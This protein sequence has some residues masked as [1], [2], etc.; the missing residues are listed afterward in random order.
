M[1]CFSVPSRGWV[2]TG[3]SDPDVVVL[4][5]LLLSFLFM[6]VKAADVWLLDPELEREELLDFRMMLSRD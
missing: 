5:E 3:G 4:R 6:V 1:D 2:G